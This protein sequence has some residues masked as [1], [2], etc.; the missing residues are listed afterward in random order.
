MPTT[1][2]GE[3]SSATTTGTGNDVKQTAPSVTN[4]TSDRLTLTGS[5]SS[6]SWGTAGLQF[7]AGGSTFTDTTSSGTVADMY[8]SSVATSTIAASSLT[9]YTSAAT[10]QVEAPTAG[11]NV[12]ITSGWAIRT[13]GGIELRHTDNVQ[14]FSL[15][16]T[17]TGAIFTVRD[18]TAAVKVQISGRASELGIRN[19]G[20]YR[21]AATV[22]S[23][24]T[25]NMAS[26]IENYVFSGTTATWTLPT[27]A[28]TP[29][30]RWFI[31]NRGSGDLTIVTT[32]AA[33]EIYTTSAVNTTTVA[34]GASAILLGDGT[35]F[36]VE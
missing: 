33:N 1:I 18:N 32:A 22:S 15:S 4:L 16:T 31:K 28:S 34:A 20:G 23:A 13:K 8:V 10:W 11:T 5:L 12:T 35:Y 19:D 6:A 36:N 27:I 29:S 9:T 14:N 24:G 25:L 3:I 30:A 26:T 17:A 21:S 7:K 2:Q